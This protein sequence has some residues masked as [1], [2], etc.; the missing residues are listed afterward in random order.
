MRKLGVIK[1]LKDG[2]KDMAKNKVKKFAF[3]NL[4]RAIISMSIPTIIFVLSLSAFGLGLF[5]FA[6]ELE[7]SKNNP[8]LIYD[9]FEVEDVAELVE[10]K[11]NGSGEYYLD[12]VDDIDDKLQE[13]IDKMNK[14]GKYHNVPDDIDFLKKMIKAEVYTQFPDLG[15]TVPA[16]TD[17]FQGAVQIRRVTPNKEIGEMKNTGKG[18][19]SNLEQGT[20][21]EPVNIENRN[22]QNKIDSWQSGQKLKIITSETFLYHDQYGAGYWEPILVEGTSTQEV[23]LKRGD[24][25][26]YQGEYETYNNGLT[27]QQTIYLKVVT[28]DDLEGYVKSGTV[29]AMI[30]DTTQG[31]II[32]NKANDNTRLA[33]TS[34]VADSREEIGVEGEK[35]VVAIAAGRNSGE[36]TGIVNE[37]KGLVEEELTIKVAERVEELLNQYS[38]IEVIQTGSTADNPDGVAPED[39]AEKTRNANPDL[40]IQIYFGDGNEVGVQT[41]YKSGDQISQQ[42]A[43]ILAENISSSMD[44]N[45][46]LS[47]SD[48]EK[49]VDNA[50]NTSSLNII[51]N[52]VVAGFPSVVVLGGNLSKDPD[53]S[54]IADDGIEKYAKGIVDGINEYFKADHTGLVA[55][56]VEDLTFTDS[57]ESR[58]INMKYVSP[59]T[60]QNY[61]DNGNMEEAIKYYTLDDDRNVV[62]ASWSQKEDG[63]IE[64]KTS[65]SMNLKTALEKYVMPYEYLLYFYI[66]TD[67][68]DFVEDLADEVMNSE[69]VI[70]V[71][72]EITTTHTVETTEQMTDA[73]LDRFDVDWHTTNTHDYITETVSTKVNLTYVSTWCVKTYQEN[74]Y[75]EA[76]LNIGDEKEIITEVPGRVTETSSTTKGADTIIVDDAEDVYTHQK[77]DEEGR[78][79]FDEEGRPVYVQDTY[80]YDILEHIITDTHTIS[81]SYEKGEYKTEGRENAFVKLYND[82]HMISKVRTE[83]YL[84]GIIE[85]NEKTANLL[86]LTK[87]LIY[88]ATNVPYGVLSFDFDVYDLSAFESI[89]GNRTSAFLEFM[90]VWEGTVTDENG[91]YIVA[92]DGVGIPTVGF[93]I[94]LRYNVDRFASK[95]VY[96]VENWQ[97]GD[98]CYTK[99]G[100]EN[101]IIDS[102]MMEE[103]DEMRNRVK[104][105]VVSCSPALNEQQIDALTA[106]SYQYGGIGN[107]VEMWNKYGNTE[108]LRDNV[109]Q[110]GQ[111][112]YYFKQNP[113]IG[114][115]EANWKLFHE[116][117]YTDKEGNEIVGSS[118]SGDILASCETVM[119]EWLDRG[120]TYSI[121]NLIWGDIEAASNYSSACCATYVSTVLYRSG[122]LTAEQINAYN[123]HWTGSGGVPDMLAAAGWTQHSYSEAQPGD[124]IV[125]YTVHTLIY[126]GG[127]NYYD[128]TCAMHQY[129]TAGSVRTGWSYYAN[130]NVQVWRAP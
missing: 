63:S 78:L 16:N 14:S 118:G 54:V 122:L 82:H 79:V 106:I 61:V 117:I 41:I 123:F 5:D 67:Y 35:Y 77:V 59:E 116:G 25:V 9:T 93:G 94:A 55:E 24:I 37:E 57:V 100:V 58:I 86:D 3:A 36:D 72:D 85:N 8:E 52:S 87:Y 20:V 95:G 98:N 99:Y 97:I 68:E 126:A 40:C 65:N 15:G 45:N 115:A 66:D 43:D 44:L 49:Y 27:G 111:W 104:S 75:S 127:N 34:R 17:G 81:N 64:I 38:N 92:D 7:T 13:I 74:S 125:D 113:S 124:V 42:L 76:V 60:M 6:I 89:S 29:N 46:L 91:N 88:K 62:I 108:E 30:D 129:N 32:T 71:Q 80:Y 48:T 90:K 31:Q 56:Q 19:T 51:D 22:D 96:G 70:A 73:T 26:T 101:S 47:I 69:I 128:Q 33:S 28:E 110:T 4:K 120:V 105:Q 112:A 130:R 39:R 102:V 2:A 107:F 121:S 10:I 53:A 12:F 84:F 23:T 83:D 11:E 21:N 109:H 114:R 119:Q 1:N 50:G 103:L 18:E